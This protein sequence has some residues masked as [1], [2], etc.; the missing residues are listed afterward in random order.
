MTDADTARQAADIRSIVFEM[1]VD[2]C[3]KQILVF[4][5]QLKKKMLDSG[6]SRETTD[7]IIREAF[8]GYK[9]LEIF[10]RTCA[11]PMQQALEA[12]LT[13]SRRALDSLGRILTEYAMVRAPKRPLV[14][15]ERSEEDDNAREM[16]VRGVL[17]RP[18]LGYF[19]V[20]LRGSVEG[21]DDFESRPVLFGSE[22]PVMAERQQALEA[23]IEE[24]TRHFRFGKR[25]VDWKEV[26][27]DRRTMRIGLEL[28]GDVLPAL[29]NLGDARFLKIVQNIQGMDKPP[30]AR[31][32][33]QR[34]FALSDVRLLKAGL[35]RAWELLGK[36]VG[37]AEPAA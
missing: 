1:A 19:L 36:T 5:R 25:S 27:K 13:P 35:Q 23:I 32:A 3:R 11:A 7:E 24:H 15:E 30:D 22:N 33:M 12:Y 21:V 29:D 10:H 4:S 17:P 26:Y 8:R 34:E 20:A 6:I 2:G 14:R 9:S 28:I 37:S 31:N 16:I 18:F